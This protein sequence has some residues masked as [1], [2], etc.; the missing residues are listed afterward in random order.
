MGFRRFRVS[1]VVLCLA[2]AAS[3]QGL[4]LVHVS[5]QREHFLSHLLRCF[6]GV[7]DNNGLGWAKMWT[8]VSPCLLH[9]TQQRVVQVIRQFSGLRPGSTTRLLF[10]VIAITFI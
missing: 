10:G 6:A 3:F 2:P 5:A 7:S 4:T 1:A 8:S 9:D